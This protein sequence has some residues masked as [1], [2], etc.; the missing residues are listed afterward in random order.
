MQFAPELEASAFRSS[1]D[2]LAWRRPQALLAAREI[3]RAGLAILGGELWLVRG[4]ELFGLL[5]QHSGPPALYGWECKRNPSEGW[6]AF[7]SRC[8]EEALSAI[9]SL[10]A[11]GEVNAPRGAE[12]YYNFIWVAEHE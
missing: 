4:G 9:E 6:P 12:V 10:P 1:E 8:C 7:V 3:A 2:E 11:E 5:P